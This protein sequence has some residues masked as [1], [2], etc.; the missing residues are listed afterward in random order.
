MGNYIMD[1]NRRETARGGPPRPSGRANLMAG[2]QSKT[3][4]EPGAFVPFEEDED[5]EVD[6]FANI[7]KPAQPRSRGNPPQEEKK[8]SPTR[9]ATETP[10]AQ[11][12]PAEPK[13]EE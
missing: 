4:T 5:E 8:A 3:I 12:Q 13:Q 2:R 9:S 6:M 10:Q 1:R 11:K 7:L